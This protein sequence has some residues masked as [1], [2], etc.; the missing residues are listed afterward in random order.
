MASRL[1]ENSERAGEFS[2]DELCEI[3]AVALKITLVG[4]R[5]PEHPQKWPVAESGVRESACQH[6][7]KTSF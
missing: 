5:Y 3:N 4:A 7:S 1:E 2:R 6:K